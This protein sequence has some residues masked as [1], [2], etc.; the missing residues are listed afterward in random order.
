VVKQAQARFAT[1]ERQATVVRMRHIT[2]RMVKA[3]IEERLERQLWDWK[4]KYIMC[5]AMGEWC[6][7]VITNCTRKDGMKGAIE[8]KERR[9]R[10]RFM[11]CSACAKC[12][13]P[14][15]MCN[16]YRVNGNAGMNE[17][18]SRVNGTGSWRR[19]CL[20]CVMHTGSC[21]NHGRSD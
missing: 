9:V 14:Q 6:G 17:F 21:G 18:R 12:G 5:R 2:E 19:R 16:R 8:V 1:Q 7:H 15:S 11:D 20:G 10:I 3:D 13:V 4:G